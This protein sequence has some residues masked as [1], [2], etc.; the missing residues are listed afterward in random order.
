MKVLSGCE[1][2]LLATSRLGRGP[3]CFMLRKDECLRVQAADLAPDGAGTVPQ[4]AGIEDFKAPRKMENGD[5]RL[6]EA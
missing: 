2:R 5:I 3:L 6:C 1:G 4:S